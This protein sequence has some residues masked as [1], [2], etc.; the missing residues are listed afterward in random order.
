YCLTLQAR[1]QHIRRAKSTSNI[2]SN[3]ALCNLAATVYMTLMGKEGLKEVA[4]QS[5]TKA[6]YLAGKIS[7]ING[8]SLAFEAPFFK[9]FAIKTPV[10]AKEIIEKLKSKN[11]FPGVDLKQFGYENMLLIAVTEKK[12][13][14]ELDQ[15]VR[16]LKELAG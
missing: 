6:H 3:E 2:C 5:T 14:C 1:E 7:K 13:K 15:F 9:E 12:R 8:F 4:I 10:L 16:E 11:I